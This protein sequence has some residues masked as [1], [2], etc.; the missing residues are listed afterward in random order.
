N[1]ILVD[2]AGTVDVL[3][4]SR[5]HV[6]FVKSPIGGARSASAWSEPHRISGSNEA[7]YSAIAQSA[8]GTIHVLYTENAIVRTHS[9]DGKTLRESVFYRRSADGGVTW[10]APVRLSTEDTTRGTSRPQIRISGSLIVAAWDDG[11]DNLNAKG[12]P[13]QGAIRRS[14]DG[15]RTWEPV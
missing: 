15:G 7:Y 4:R 13:T 1:S 9:P 12:D 14:L 8:D 6:W 2:Q 10:T 11:Y 3:Y 5:E